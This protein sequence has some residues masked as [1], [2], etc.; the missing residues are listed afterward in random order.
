M[1]SS[2][3]VVIGIRSHVVSLD[4][5]TGNEL[6]RRKLKSGQFVTIYPRND[7]VY[8]GVA[9]ELFSLDRTDGKILWHNKLPRLGYGLVSFAA[10]PARRMPHDLIVGTKGHVV[11]IDAT[12]GRETWRTR[13]ASKMSSQAVT[14]AM[15]D[16]QTILAGSSGELFAV[17]RSTG[18]V[19]WRARL[20]GLGFGLV[21]LGS[22]EVTIATAMAQAQAAAAAAA[23]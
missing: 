2:Q 18:K 20:E 22:N 12:T 13:L 1:K 19:L 9:G 23:S 16:E 5:T 17:H 10:D 11:A 6:W 4:P 21:S 8:A 15:S 7:R 3:P 14:L